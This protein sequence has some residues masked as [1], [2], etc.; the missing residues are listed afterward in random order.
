MKVKFADYRSV[1]MVRLEVYETF[2]QRG[3]GELICEANELRTEA[4]EVWCKAKAKGY[5]MMDLGPTMVDG[6]RY[7]IKIS[8]RVEFKTTD[9]VIEL[10]GI[11]IKH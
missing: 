11:T 4:H 1:G 3:I 2:G 5:E 10:P 8:V 6:G 9:E 7:G